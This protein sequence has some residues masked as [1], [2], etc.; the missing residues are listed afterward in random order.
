[1]SNL[2][3]MPHGWGQGVCLFAT[4]SD[5]GYHVVTYSV[6]LAFAQFYA[7]VCT[8]RCLRLTVKDS[9]SVNGNK[10]VEIHIS[11]ESTTLVLVH[12]ALI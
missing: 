3:I 5:V 4:L 8:G 7:V 10:K 9:V 12:Q 6:G 1:M 2:V 11:F